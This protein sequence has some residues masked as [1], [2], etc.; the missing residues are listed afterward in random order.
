[1]RPIFSFISDRVLAFWLPIS[2]LLVTMIIERVSGYHCFT[3]CED[4]PME[5][6]QSLV[7]L[8]AFGI[9]LCILRMPRDAY[10]NWARVFFLIGV[11]GS[12]YVA[13]EEISYGQRIFGWVT[14]DAWHLV[15]DQ[16]ETNLHN[17]SSWLDQ[18]PR[19]ILEIGVFIGGI[20][21]PL[22]RRFAPHKLPQQFAVV[23]PNNAL[24]FT[25]VMAIGMHMI[26]EIM[27]GLNYQDYYLVRR[28][29]EIL[30]LY[31]YWFILLYFIF[32]RRELKASA[33]HVR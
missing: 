2:F 12:I 1:M 3:G 19:A 16:Q 22:M 33:T 10:P 27:E 24:C 28:P 15:N 32:K 25:A 23:Y 7:M 26:Q 20:V 17:T 13:L 6:F 21:I 18:K 31:L 14:P 4:G 30:E 5:N 29:S 8:T 9:G 11:V